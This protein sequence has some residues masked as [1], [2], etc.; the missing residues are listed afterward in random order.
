MTLREG[1]S[2]IPEEHQQVA[3]LTH[4]KAI[5]GWKIEEQTCWRSRFSPCVLILLE[6]LTGTCKAA[7]I[8]WN[9][10]SGFN[11]IIC[12]SE[13]IY[14]NKGK[15]FSLCLGKQWLLGIY[16]TCIRKY[17]SIYIEKYA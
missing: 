1:A 3:V 5:T 15:F 4:S 10:V 9:L 6:E 7:G 12:H 14:G 17:A 16:K 13:A 11:V 2:Q 8:V